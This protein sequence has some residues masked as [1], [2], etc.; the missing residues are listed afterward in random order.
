MGR[1]GSLLVSAFGERR[2]YY[3]TGYFT[4]RAHRLRGEGVGEA[5][6]ER[7]AVLWALWTSRNR[8]G[9]GPEVQLPT[10]TPVLFLLDA[11]DPRESP[12]WMAPMVQP[13]IPGAHG[14]PANGVLLFANSA[15]AI[16]R[17]DGH[18]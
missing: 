12:G 13:L 18:P 7:I 15:A 8:H 17:L 10:G 6:P 5:F 11:L 3:E 14:P 9:L 4:A 16:Y 2:S 1:P